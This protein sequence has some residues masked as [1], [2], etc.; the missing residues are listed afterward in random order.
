VHGA[1]KI[2]RTY[3]GFKE[4]QPADPALAE[5]AEFGNERGNTTGRLRQTDWLDLERLKRACRVNGVTHLT[6]SKCDV[7]RKVKK[8]KAY[9][10]AFG[11]VTFRDFASL[12]DRIR[13]VIPT[14]S[15][16]FSS[17]PES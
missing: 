1:A 2:Y 8:F 12:V 16:L 17:S 14:P 6:I 10:G 3:S 4:F 13:Q 9:D 11:L 5:L 7:L 15:I